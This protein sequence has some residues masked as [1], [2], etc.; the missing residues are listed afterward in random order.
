MRWQAHGVKGRTSVR[1]LAVFLKLFYLSPLLWGTLPA[2]FRFE[3][4]THSKFSL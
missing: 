1:P 4:R 2:V 3:E